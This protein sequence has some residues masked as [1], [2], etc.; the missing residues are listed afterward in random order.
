MFSSVR[1]WG[2]G[3]CVLP[4]LPGGCESQG[5]SERCTGSPS[6]SHSVHH[7]MEKKAA[8]HPYEREQEHDSDVSGEYVEPPVWWIVPARLKMSDFSPHVPVPST[9][10]VSCGSW[11]LLCGFFFSGVDLLQ[12]NNVS[13]EM[14]A[15][16]FPQCFSPYT[17]FAQRL[18]IEG[19][20]WFWHLEATGKRNLDFY[21]LVEFTAVINWL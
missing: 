14:L 7:Q 4:A 20:S 8:R 2:G 17:E 9:S 13:F 10:E 1:V 12:Y 6:G 15:S 11:L 16:V 3:M 21:E 19:K 18:K 5:Q